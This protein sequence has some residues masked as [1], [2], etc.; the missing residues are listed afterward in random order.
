M[1]FSVSEFGL[2]IDMVGSVL[3]E[4]I[5]YIYYYRDLFVDMVLSLSALHLLELF[6]C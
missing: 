3:G 5:S 2:Y 4:G 6:Y 1:V